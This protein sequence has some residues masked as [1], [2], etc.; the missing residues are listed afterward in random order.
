P[1]ATLPDPV[2]A[3]VCRIQALW[4]D[5]RR[6]HDDRAPFLFGAFSAADAMY[7]PV[8]ARFRTYLPDL[9]PYGDDG[10]AEAYI[11]GM[12][13]SRAPG[14]RRWPAQPARVAFA[15]A[16]LTDVDRP[17]RNRRPHPIMPVPCRRCSS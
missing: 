13:G 10:N 4:R 12:G 6:R 3:E 11:A 17:P 9:R 8:A 2:A 7:A 1:M 16:R 14:N 15:K 5:Y